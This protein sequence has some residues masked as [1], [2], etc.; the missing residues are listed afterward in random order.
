MRVHRGTEGQDPDPLI[1]AKEGPDAPAYRGLAYVVFERLALAEWGNRLPQL[2]FEVVRPVHGLGH[3]I[4]AV[5]L[6]PGSG[7]F[8]LEPA[9]VTQDDGLGASTALNVHQGWAASDWTAS[10]DALQALCPNLQRVTL[11][12]AWF[13]D[14]MRAGS[15]TVA[16]RVETAARATGGAEWSVAG[17]SRATARVSSLTQG[18][19]A[20]GGTPSDAS[21]VRA[22]RD[23]K[24]RGLAVT[25]HPFLLMDVPAGNALPD[26]RTGAAGQPAYPWRGRITCHPAPGRPGSPDATAAAGAQV[27]A[28]VGASKA[29]DFRLDGES[30]TH[31]RPPAWTLSRQVLH[32][33][34]LAKAAGGVEAMLIGSEL[35]GVTRV[36]SAPGVYPAAG[37][38]AALAAEVK[39]VLPGAKV[40][41]AADWTEY[42]SHVPEAGEL[43]FPLDPLWASPAI[44]AVAIDA[45][46]PLAD[47]RD[48]AGHADAARGRSAHDP[49][50]LLANTAAGESFD[51]YYA[52]ADD[53]AAQRRSPITDGAY[54]KPWVYRTK[55]L[56]G[57]WS[58]PHIERVG[59]VERPS[60]TAW[61]PRGKPIWLAEVGC[62][63]I[64]K[65]ANTPSA[66]PDAKSSEDTRPAFS[67]GRRDDLMLLR[68]V[69]AMLARF[70]PS[71]PRTRRARTRLPRSMAG[72][73]STPPARRCGR[74]TRGRSRRSRSGSTRGR[75][76]GPGRPGTG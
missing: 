17:L 73:W 31:L 62:P 76:A 33:A 61:A 18:R 12:V 3:A 39:A 25:L 22:I 42:G 67:D 27:T 74:G 56:V 52:S 51:W 35:V 40:S 36:R 60:P 38:L 2:T 66:F 26:P 46:W 44:D 53:R 11:L 34:W 68:G 69:E 29:S 4:R 55:D 8:A 37:L 63:A 16:P 50:M 71:H 13:G 70:D 6:L 64:D 7:E 72:R 48:G 1:V 43:R 23:L 20:Y 21:V 14:D 59:G 5:N 30:V 45:W 75:T 41:Y 58:N 10:I 47:W 54:G 19:P 57:W 49:A 15:C 9:P 65:G 24:A 32:Y 28:F